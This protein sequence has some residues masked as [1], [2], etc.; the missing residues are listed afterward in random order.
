MR[1]VI[2]TN[3]LVS[4]FYG[5]KPREVIRLWEFL[6][7]PSALKIEI[8]DPE[9]LKFLECA[10]A[11]KAQF[12]ISGDRDLLALRAFGSVKILSPAEFLDRVL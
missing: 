8:S 3:V 4:S 12:V 10:V 5:G 2:D 11:L 7:R 9:D 1:A 6:A